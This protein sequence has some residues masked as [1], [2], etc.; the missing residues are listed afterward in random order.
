MIRACLIWGSNFDF[1]FV[2]PHFERVDVLITPLQPVTIL[3]RCVRVPVRD[4]DP[5]GTKLFFPKKDQTFISSLNL[6]ADSVGLHRT[7]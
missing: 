1:D 2:S 7:V 5:S 6:L 4:S 3:R